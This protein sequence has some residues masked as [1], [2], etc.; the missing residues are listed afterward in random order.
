MDDG[1]DL[2]CRLDRQSMDQPPQ[3]VKRLVF[4]SQYLDKE[5]SDPTKCFLK[6]FLLRKEVNKNE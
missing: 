4:W 1:L 2:F 6:F 5:R 3:H